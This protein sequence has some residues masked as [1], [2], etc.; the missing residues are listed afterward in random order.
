LILD[1]P[2]HP[3]VTPSVSPAQENIKF[4]VEVA[5]VIDVLDDSDKNLRSL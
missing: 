3:V 4:N 1:L 2:L 5:P